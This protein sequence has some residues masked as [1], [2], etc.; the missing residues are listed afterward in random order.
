MVVHPPGKVNQVIYPDSPQLMAAAAVGRNGSMSVGAIA[1]AQQQPQMLATPINSPGLQSRDEGGDL[2][3]TP[4]PPPPPPN[5]AQGGGAGTNSVTPENSEA[6]MSDKS[7]LQQLILYSGV[8]AL[9]L[10]IGVFLTNRSVFLGRGDGTKQ[11]TQT[12]QNGTPPTVPM[13]IP[14]PGQF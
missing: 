11:P 9:A 4:P 10:L 14:S 5:S 12:A 7:F 13:G 3:L 6:A 2:P 1:E 8:T